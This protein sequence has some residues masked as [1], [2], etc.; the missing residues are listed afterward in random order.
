MQGVSYGSRMVAS[1]PIHPRP[2]VS[3]ADRITLLLGP[4]RSGKTA[5]CLKRFREE[6]GRSLL[7]V[8][9]RPYA[10]RLRQRLPKNEDEKETEGIH[11]FGEMAA[12]IAG[13][14]SGAH[15]IG[16]TAKRLALADIFAQEIGPD[17]FFGKMRGI[18]GFVGALADFLRELK[19][20]GITPDMLEAGAEAVADRIEDPHFR[21]ETSELA[22]LYGCYEQFL[23]EHNL[24]DEDDLPRLAAEKL[25]TG[26]PI[27]NEARC[28]LVDGFYRFPR[29]WRDLLAA[30]IRR[31]LKV[32]VTLPYEEAR[33]LLFA[34]SARTLA[35]FRAEFS[36]EEVLLPAPGPGGRPSALYALERG[37][38]RGT[39]DAGK[40]DTA[41][42]LTLFDAPNA[43]TEA[44]MAARTLLRE[45]NERGTPWNRCAIIARSP[46][47]YADILTAVCERY[48]IPLAI[49]RT[50]VVA[51]NPLIRTLM[52]L[53]N[54]FLRG[55][56]RDDVIAFLKSSYTSAD[57]LAADRLRRRASRRGLREGCEGW[58]R[59][60]TDMKD[61]GDP[62]TP[63]LEKM[64]AWHMELHAQPCRADTF[65]ET[66]E[67]LCADLNLADSA[68]LGDRAALKQAGEVLAEIALTTRL[69]GREPA[70][71]A[72]F[73]SQ[74]MT[75]WQTA[76][77]VP[78]L[79]R[80]AVT[81]I[82]PLEAGARDLAFVIVMGLTERV[83]P[84]QAKEDPFLRDDERAMLREVGL[85][86]EAHGERA[87]DERLL[88]YQAI[89]APSER[90]VLSYPRAEEESDTLRSFY[91]DEVLDLFGHVPTVTRLL[92]D[93]APRPEEC[94][95][96][97]DRILAA[98]AAMAD[99]QERGAPQNV[100]SSL[101]WLDGAERAAVAE[102]EKT[103]LCPRLARLESGELRHTF[104]APRRYN[105]SEIETYLQCPFQYLAKY[106]LKLRTMPGGAGAAERGKLHHTVLR[107]HFR[108]RAEREE[109]VNAAE[110]C[111]ALLERLQ[112]CL[113][114]R[115]LDARP[116]RAR[117]MERAL[118]DA[119][120]GFA[121][122]EELFRELFNLLPAY[123]ELRFGLEE[124]PGQPED[125]PEEGTPEECDP[126]ST[127]RPLRIPASDGGPPIEICGVID[128]VD[129]ASDGVT[130]LVMDYKTGKS[131]PF[132]QIRDGKSL[133]MPVY[134][135]ALE[136]LWGLTG[137]VGCYDS[138]HDSGRRRFYRQDKVDVQRFRPAPGED[139]RLAKPVGPEKWG[140]VIQAVQETIRRFV[141]QVREANV[142]PAP[143]D[144]CRS[145]IYGDICRTSRDNVHDGE[146]VPLSN[147]PSSDG[148][149]HGTLHNHVSVSPDKFAATFT[150]SSESQ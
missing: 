25:D 150:S 66:L 46:G 37:I 90:L 48:G 84:R 53:L 116:H 14:E 67:R 100:A 114:E 27:P 26:A 147:L 71:L 54:V 47:D 121:E 64:L 40:R 10:E 57:K 8:P 32:V 130:A 76:T 126:A 52:T 28:V 122:R 55:W 7:L 30:F 85:P 38:F 29:V 94:V 18:P 33:P 51:D 75:G 142:L 88:F 143:G 105:V 6:K 111:E 15:V 127:A 136:Q 74:A 34:A 31:G 93:V 97:R 141:S 16:Q 22:R 148:G 3:S 115:P 132:E 13:T 140:E 135:M 65:R 36:V 20:S 144:H 39:K 72:E 50:R 61:A 137:A 45:H 89:A 113:T 108:A 124:D 35:L 70:S 98:C 112:E 5:F 95:T 106:G 123:F 21:Q 56:Q 91:I 78:P 102:I 9:T 146:P 11:P 12:A 60:A 17:D 118:R 125:E 63:T 81:L 49:S 103:R 120:C 68:E 73:C 131:V 134:L 129:V 86:L 24:R 104:A 145:C 80:D 62:L 82:E 149:T 133:Q 109:I 119:L 41:E 96:P 107:R 42:S 23:R 117:M 101:S 2:S 138:P 44:E 92:T 4:A 83:F 59:L 110:M 43:Y 77:Y 128:R 79:P 99:A 139:G 58:Q 69:T 87:D 19:L 1:H